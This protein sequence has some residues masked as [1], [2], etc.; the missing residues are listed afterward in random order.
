[1]SNDNDI[2]TR[3]IASWI[4]SHYNLND[5]K[6]NTE[7]MI[8]RIRDWS[9]PKKKRKIKTTNKTKAD[10]V[11]ELKLFSKKDKELE[12]ALTKSRKQIKDLRAQIKKHEIKRGEL[13][14]RVALLEQKN[15]EL[16]EY[17]DRFDIMDL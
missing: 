16:L 13:Q 3:E 6:K 2:N 15:K 14:N 1:M 17:Y 4:N 11:V 7:W 8:K 5:D 12:Q 10:L 9:K